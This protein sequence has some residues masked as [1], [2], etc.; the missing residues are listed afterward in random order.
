[1][2]LPLLLHLSLTATGPAPRAVQCDHADSRSA[3]LS[4]ARSLAVDAHAGSLRVEG[5][6]DATGVRIEARLCA[7]S[8]AL[9]DGMRLETGVTDGRA[10]IEAVI[11]EQLNGRSYA[12]MDLVIVVPHG[13][14]ARIADGSGEMQLSGLGATRVNDGSGSAEITDI[15]GTLDIEDG[16]GELDIRDVSGDV[17]IDDGSGALTVA[18]VQGSVSIDDGS[19]EIRLTEVR[20]NVV[21]DDSSGG[22]RVDRVGG[23]FTVTDDGSGGIRYTDVAGTV[24]IPPDRRR[25]S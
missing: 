10:E 6:A 5:R 18:N 21:I 23:D 22:I 4:G 15:R 25:G 16:S 14:P 19:G 13:M 3:S 1:M 20:R 12:R 9:L 2:L 24:R 8:R 11:P 7:S 17:S